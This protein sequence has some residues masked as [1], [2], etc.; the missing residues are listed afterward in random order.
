MLAGGVRC[1]RAQRR[2]TASTAMHWLGLF[3]SGSHVQASGAL[4]LSQEAR[5]TANQN[6]Q[7]S[8]S[9]QGPR[10]H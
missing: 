7:R 1:E 9:R 8:E 6:K 4:R 5:A 10:P 3:F 2:P